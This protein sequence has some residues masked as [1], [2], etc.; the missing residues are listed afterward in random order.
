[1]ICSRLQQSFV[2]DRDDTSCE[3][4]ARIRETHGFP[5]SRFVLG[6]SAPP[7]QCCGEVSRRSAAEIRRGGTAT[8]NLDPPTTT[9]VDVFGFETVL[10]RRFGGVDDF[11]APFVD[12]ISTG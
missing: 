2:D 9:L 12:G 11:L 5:G 8:P 3:A 1:M 4:L 6:V 7:S 10:H